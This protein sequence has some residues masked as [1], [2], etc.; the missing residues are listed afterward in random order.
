MNGRLAVLVRFK[1]NADCAKL[2][3]TQDDFDFVRAVFERF[4]DFDFDLIDQIVDGRLF[5]RHN[6]GGHRFA[7][8]FV[9]GGEDGGLSRR[10]VRYGGNG[11]G[12]RGG[13]RGFNVLS[14]RLHG[15]KQRLKSVVLPNLLLLFLLLS[16]DGARCWL[17]RGGFLRRGRFRRQRGKR[18]RLLGFGLRFCR[19]A[20]FFVFGGRSRSRFQ[21]DGGLSRLRFDRQRD[22]GV[23]GQFFR[24]FFG[25]LLRA[26]KVFGGSF[27]GRV[28][29]FGR[30]RLQRLNPH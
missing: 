6:G 2:F 16:R 29:D 3:G 20:G 11:S 10:G 22:F 24:Q 5:L 14:R 27:G 1:A 12:N 17:S 25:L 26:F 18:F 30:F 7:F 15:R 21:S 4:G 23:R 19:R 13:F 28:L 9:R 8:Q